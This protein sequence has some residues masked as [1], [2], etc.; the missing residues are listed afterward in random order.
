MQEDNSKELKQ[1]VAQY[2]FK[3]E[4]EIANQFFRD[5]KHQFP[6]YIE[7]LKKFETSI[8]HY[9]NKIDMGYSKNYVEFN[10]NNGIE[11]VVFDQGTLSDLDMSIEGI[12]EEDFEIVK[13]VMGKNKWIEFYR[14]YK[15]YR[16]INKEL[17]LHFFI[18]YKLLINVQ[19]ELSKLQIER[20]KLNI[21]YSKLKDYNHIREAKVAL[22]RKENNELANDKKNLEDYIKEYTK[23]LEDQIFKADY[24]I[25]KEGRG[26]FNNNSHTN[27]MDELRIYIERIINYN[28]AINLKFEEQKTSND[29]ATKRYQEM[30]EEYNKK[31]K[32]VTILNKKLEEMQ[33]LYGREKEVKPTVEIISETIIKEDVRFKKDHD[34]YYN[35]DLYRFVIETVQECDD[36]KK[37]KRQEAVAKL[38]VNSMVQDFLA[39]T[40]RFKL[41]TSSLIN[42]Y[43]KAIQIVGE[44]YGLTIEDIRE[45]KTR[46]RLGLKTKF[47][48]NK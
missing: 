32:E 3:Q 36:G 1:L 20:D 5:I 40:N 43:D 44:E 11:E 7:E 8:Q 42:L 9:L 35:D 47:R 31:V 29:M 26:G 2:D 13:I 48:R 46:E 38:E 21:S 41:T 12:D 24:S 30:L 6:V 37:L 18:S 17:R 4:M 45:R 27:K 33:D 16:K 23:F 15:M 22:L 25:E 39:N 19:N 14:N 34:R 28:I 10:A